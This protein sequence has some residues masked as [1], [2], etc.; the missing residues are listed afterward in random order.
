MSDIA[1]ALV[2]YQNE[3]KALERQRW[4]KEI[5]GIIDKFDDVDRDQAGKCAEFLR[6]RVKVSAFTE[7]F[8]DIAGVDQQ[9]VEMV[10]ADCD[11]EI[12]LDTVIDDVIVDIAYAE[13]AMEIYRGKHRN[14]DGE[15]A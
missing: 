14:L 6:K 7:L 1:K 2:H 11:T 8:R 5:A 3:Q 10:L 13:V 9:A 12:A 15:A 4:E